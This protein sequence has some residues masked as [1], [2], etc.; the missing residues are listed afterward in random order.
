[1]RVDVLSCGWKGGPIGPLGALEAAVAVLCHVTM[2]SKGTLLRAHFS[3]LYMGDTNTLQAD[4]LRFVVS[5]NCDEIQE[6]VKHAV[7]VVVISSKR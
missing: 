2:D 6:I 3:F 1:M 4:F 7:I 5:I